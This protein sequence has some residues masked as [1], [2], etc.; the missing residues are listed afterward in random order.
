MI[1][2]KMRL[3]RNRLF[4]GTQ[5]ANLVSVQFH[6][7]SNYYFLVFYRFTLMSIMFV[8]IKRQLWMSSAKRLPV[9]F[10]ICYLHKCYV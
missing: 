4:R 5:L 8:E 7:F 9:K 1:A 3:M 10:L 6:D 2:L